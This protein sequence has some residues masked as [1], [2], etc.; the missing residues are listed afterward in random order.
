MMEIPVQFILTTLLSIIGAG[1]S[2]FFALKIANAENRKDIEHLIE[3][4]KDLSN[5]LKELDRQC[6]AHRQSENHVT[7]GQIRVLEQRIADM[8]KAD[9]TAHS[10]LES[11]LDKLADKVDQMRK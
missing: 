3:M 6:S 4:G 5:N 2:V 8:L 1:L 11:K 7:T 9:E 10:R